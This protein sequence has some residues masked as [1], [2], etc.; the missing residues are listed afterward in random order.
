MGKHTLLERFVTRAFASRRG[1]VA[2]LAAITVILGWFAWQVEI[3]TV[4]ADLLPQ[5][6][7]YVTVHERF[8]ETFGGSNVVSIMVEVADGDI[9]SLP[10]LGKVQAITN[11]LSYVD[12]VNTTQIVSLATRKLREIRATT[13]GIDSRPLMH[14][15]LPAGEQAL[16]DLRAAVVKNPLVYGSYVSL[17]LKAALITVDF[18]DQKLDYP[19]V[20]RQIRAIADEHSGGGTTVRVVGDPVLYGWV[21][22]YVPETLHILLATV[23]ALVSLLFVVARTLRGTVLPLL[24]G[25]TSAVWALG[26]ARLLGYHMDPLV[27]V[28]AFLI[29]ARSISHA[30]QVVTCFD[31]EVGDGRATM[32]EAAK[33]SMRTLLKPGL[34]GVFADAGAMLVVILTPIPLMQKISLIGTIWVLTIGVTASITTPL[35]LTW[36]RKPNA[37]AHSFDLSPYLDRLLRLCVRVAV[38]PARFWV[39]GLTA[40][41]FVGSGLYAFN[42]KVGDANP[43]SPILWPDSRYNTDAAAINGRFP[44]ADRMFVVLAG[45]QAD[46]VKDPEVLASMERFQ[47][48]MEAQ[49]EVG[50]TLSL[51][52]ILPPVRAILHEGNP[53]YLELGRT[54]E[55]N[56]ESLFMLKA[57]AD[58]GDL[59]RFVDPT[60]TDGAV[61]LFFRDHRGDTIQTAVARVKEFIAANPLP[62]ADY[63]LAGG[64][65]G[66][67]AA[68]NEVILAGQI[69]SIALALLVLV[70]CCGIAYRS[71]SAGL[72]FMVPV[73]LS[74]TLT[75]SY[76]AWK[77]IG[78]NVNTLPV[79]ALG[80]GLG[81]DYA[82]YVVDG[83]RE[84]LE[85]TD[86][87]AEAIRRSLLLGPGRGVLVTA[88]TLIT[89]V[90][91]WWLSSLRFQ[92]EMG[93]LMAIWLFI[94]AFS[95]LFI[96]PAVVFVFRPQFVVGRRG[97]DR[98]PATVF[99]ESTT[100]LIGGTQ[101]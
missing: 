30:V 24:A 76:M 11:A 94:S 83:I 63:L 66:V 96:M 18:Y 31:N 87:L 77:G 2:A 19:A 99:A 16:R 51:A 98:N 70:V 4:F 60:F 40:A 52:D 15:D 54:A 74:N 17:D 50:A 49:P 48:F 82:I 32:L 13:A 6:H 22:H 14:P 78:M 26:A 56:G 85:G 92:A 57:G 75:F 35:L 73:V 93:V 8:K 42:L 58:A 53:R 47:R 21:A 41:A 62:G 71:M 67:L 65:A 79:A 90:G 33:D 34:L 36:V 7:P 95:A 25:A 38:G 28:V 80:I 55:E 37:T 72:F 44:G 64:L 27:I 45:R 46:A 1:F 5:K 29:T 88:L 3:R 59:D 84:E 10:V 91:L 100:M 61:T 23:G 12:G 89:S 43:G 97:A 68:V 39:L 9:F 20:F 101:R 81:V 69:E 86:D